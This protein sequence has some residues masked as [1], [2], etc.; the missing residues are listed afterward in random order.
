MSGLMVRRN[1]VRCGTNLLN[2]DDTLCGYCDV[3]D[4]K[5]FETKAEQNP[6]ITKLVDN[7]NLAAG[8]VKLDDGKLRYD[9]VPPEM[10]QALADILTSGAKKYE[11]RNWEKGM[12]WGRVF[13]SLMRHMWAWWW[14]RDKDDETG[15]SHLWHAACCLAFLVTYES[16]GI[17]E[18]DRPMMGESK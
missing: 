18:D 6:P 9:L 1:C 2:N 4:T 10:L 12:R 16:R 7:M 13:A 3:V 5:Y 15:K 11:P 17:G 8:G 14:K